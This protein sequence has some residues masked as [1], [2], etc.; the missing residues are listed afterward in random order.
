MK[1]L[2]IFVLHKE[3]DRKRIVRESLVFSA[4][5]VI[6]RTAL[7][8]RRSV[9]A[10]QNVNG[11][12]NENTSVRPDDLASVIVH[13]S[14]SPDGLASVIASDSEYPQRVS[15]TLLSQ[16]MNDFTNTYPFT[17]WVQMEEQTGKLASLSESLRIYQNP[18]KADPLMALQKDL[19]DTTDIVINTL[20]NL[21]WS[22]LKHFLKQHKKQINVVLYINHLFPYYLLIS[23]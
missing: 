10:Y 12:K 4:R 13:A 22:C 16:V 1:L 15:H 14:V 8:T 7:G 21:K 5:T 9:E 2:A 6:E 20:V 18:H 17:T 23:C 3:D 19:D 11:K